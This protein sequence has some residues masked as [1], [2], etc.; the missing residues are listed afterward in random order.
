MDVPAAIREAR[1]K[2]SPTVDD[3]DLHICFSHHKRKLLN[4]RMQMRATAGQ[5]GKLAIARGTIYEI[6]QGRS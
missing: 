3:C 1:H 4:D 5:T 2:Y 6:L